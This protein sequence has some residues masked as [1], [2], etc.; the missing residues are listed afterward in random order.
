MEE[1]E[2]IAHTGGKI[3]FIY[4]EDRGVSISIKH[5]N[6]WK[7][8]YVRLA[9]SYTGTVL[10]FISPLADQDSPYPQPSFTPFLFSDREGL[11]GQTCPKC[12]SYFRSSR[13]SGTETY[14]PYCGTKDKSVDFLTENQ[15]A[16]MGKFCEGFITA[17]NNKES[18]TLDLDSILETLDGNTPKWMQPEERQQ[19]KNKCSCHCEY[20]I[21]GDY[22]ICPSCS[23]VNYRHVVTDKFDA[24]EAEFNDI[25]EHVTDRTD[26][27]IGWEKL[28]KCVSDFEDLANKLKVNLI[29][30]P[31]T[32]KRR[33]DIK[34]ISFQRL[35][36]AA[37]ALKAWF[38]IDIFKDISEV[39]QKFLNKMF[40]RR[41]IFTHNGGRV[42]EEYIKN[43][44]ED[45]LRINQKIRFKSKEIKRLIPLVRK[46]SENLISGYEAIE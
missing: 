25:D 4:E 20:D 46:C 29:N 24:F 45:D 14:C 22:G 17:H 38:D 33:S 13:I 3:D 30:I 27:E 8:A 34:Q 15:L 7:T 39:D 43:T 28:T 31:S 44:G 18:L 23:K 21:L 40:N 11:F 5:A 1:F 6:P 36:N 37:S 42:D 19:S 16:F 32:P 41:H 9:V 10:S 26:R 12:K 2:E 35:L